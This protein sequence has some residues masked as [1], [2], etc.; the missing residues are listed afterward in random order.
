MKLRDFLP[1]AIARAYDGF[2]GKSFASDFIAG[3]DVD[4]GNL[5]SNRLTL[6]YAQSAWIQ[7]A[8]NFKTSEIAATEL[9]FYAGE[10]EY[11]DKTFTAWWAKPFAA[12]GRERRLSISEGRA[13]LAAWRSIAGESFIVLNDDWLDITASRR[14]LTLSAPIIARPDRMRHIVQN[15]ELVGWMLTDGAGRQIPLLPEQVIH[16]KRFNPYND[17]RGLSPLVAIF[18]AAEGDYLAGVY[19]RNLMRNNGDQ[20]V[21]IGVKGQ[22]PSDQQREQ[23]IAQLQEKKRRAQRGES[24]MAFLPADITV[25]DA[26]AQA[27]GAEINA[28]RLA[29][30]EEIFLGLGVP[31]SMS[32]VKAS[33]SIGAAS[34]RYQLITGTCMAEAKSVDDPLAQIASLQTGKELTARA[35]WDNHPVMVDV[36]TARVTSALQ[37]W[38]AGMP[39]KAAN[40]YLGLGMK[41]FKGWD[42]GYLPFS[43]SPVDSDGAEPVADPANAE[44]LEI[45][46]AD[47]DVE[48]LRLVLLARQ[49]LS[50]NVTPLP[51]AVKVTAGADAFSVFACRCHASA[52]AEAWT[53]VEMKARDPKQLAQWRDL[54][55]KR[56][57][58][59]KLYQSKITRELFKA[60]AEVLAKIT[61]GYKPEEKSALSALNSQLSTK[62]A[63]AD[64]LFDLAKWSDGFLASMRKAGEVALDTSG[65]Q[66]FEELGRD[67]PFKFPPEAVLEY[68][69]ARENKLS[70]VPKETFDR[71]KASIE[72]GITAGDTTA[73]LADRVRSEFNEIDQGRARSIAV[74]E[75]SAAYGAGRDEAM[76]QAGIGFKQWLTSGNDNVRAAH[77]AANEQIVP[78]DGFFE[79]GG[80]QLQFPGDPAG[81]PE[82][83]IQCHCV[84]IPVETAEG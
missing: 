58:T 71:I 16:E 41:P 38:G 21:F 4:N 53:G 23:I 19:T 82:N 27:P 46:P 52:G 60:R 68:A 75:T 32:Q 29:G 74:T 17:W 66:L 47:N 45:A 78:I 6:P 15:G 24:S 36:R 73:E 64:F 59:V 33:Y 11:Q 56:R 57:S 50:K 42:V 37:L 31:P 12:P 13:Q 84:S 49:R 22:L 48:Q 3:R 28:S 39:L 10:N 44:P 43:V 65:K 62:A 9:K 83:V 55:S 69:R 81:S 8:I 63:A 72:E 51:V 1:P 80:E 35:D 34:D 79:V 2:V 26:K 40:D 54:M 14:G 7:A 5:S 70:N 20:G 67:D 30:R 77:A 61:S 18:N 76:H 25:E